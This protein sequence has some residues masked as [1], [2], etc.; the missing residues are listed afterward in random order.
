MCV[1]IINMTGESK[2][3]IPNGGPLNI[4]RQVGEFFLAHIAAVCAPSDTPAERLALRDRDSIL[5]S[6]GAAQRQ[7]ALML[8]KGVQALCMRA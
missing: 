4:D 1:T 2:N 5:A 8:A 3:H 6:M 7:N